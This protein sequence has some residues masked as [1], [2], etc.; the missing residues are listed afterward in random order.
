MDVLFYCDN[1]MG[2]R[3]SKTAVAP[4]VI[5]QH[6]VGGSLHSDANIL[7]AW[8]RK[9][10]RLKTGIKISRN[11][12]LLEIR[13]VTSAVLEDLTINIVALLDKC[14]CTHL[15]APDAT[16]MITFNYVY[17]KHTEDIEFSDKPN[18]TRHLCALLNWEKFT[19]DRLVEACEE[20]LPYADTKN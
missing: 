18:T 15:Y 8:L 19:I 14:Y 16:N 2:S 9:Q 20:I 7:S 4:I 3:G 10:Y 1:H 13:K 12:L 6:A 17:S 11:N 5:T